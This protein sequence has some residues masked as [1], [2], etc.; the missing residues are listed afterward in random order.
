MKS[1][2]ARLRCETLCKGVQPLEGF[3]HVKTILFV[4]EFESE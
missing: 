3:H 1:L 4:S 2:T